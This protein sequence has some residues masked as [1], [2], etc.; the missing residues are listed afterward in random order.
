MSIKINKIAFIAV[1]V[2]M[3]FA[4]CTTQP[5]AVPDGGELDY[6]ELVQVSLGSV[7]VTADEATTRANTPL[8]DGQKFRLYAFPKGVT[9]YSKQITSYSYTMRGGSP[10]IDP[11]QGADALYLPYGE[12]DIYMVS[13]SAV[14]IGE[15]VVPDNPDTPEDES[16]TNPI[17]NEIATKNGITVPSGV[18]FLAS[19]TDVTIK[20][21]ESNT[22]NPAVLTHKMAQVQVRVKALTD[23]TYNTLKLISV[24]VDGQTDAPQPFILGAGGGS[25]TAVEA[26]TAQVTLDNI[27]EVTAGAEYTATAVVFPR[28]ASKMKVEI[29]FL[30]DLKVAEGEEP[31]QETYLM[32][33][34]LSDL[35][36]EGGKRNALKTEPRTSLEIVW[37]PEV[38][39]WDNKPASTMPLG[40]VVFYFDGNDAPEM[41]DGKLSWRDRSGSG[42]HAVLEGNVT[43]DA[44]NKCYNLS[45]KTDLLRLPALGYIPEYTLELVTTSG[46]VNND[47]AVNFKE[48]SAAVRREIGIY[49]PYKDHIT[50]FDAPSSS[51]RITYC[52]DTD[53]ETP[54]EAQK[55][56]MYYHTFRTYHFS[57]SNVTKKGSMGVNGV[58]K[59]V[60]N[61]IATPHVAFNVNQLGGAGAIR[62]RSARLYRKV[63]TP[64]QLKANYDADQATYRQQ[65]D[66]VRDASL[67]LE[68]DGKVPPYSDGTDTY[69]P[70]MSGNKNHAKYIHIGGTNHI[71]YT[72]SGYRFNSNST[73]SSSSCMKLKNSL[74]TLHTYTLEIVCNS[75]KQNSTVFY[76]GPAENNTL[77]AIGIHLPHVNASVSNKS[78]VY[79]DSP[80]NGSITKRFIYDG[81]QVSLESL[82]ANTL[83]FAFTRQYV[84]G[85]DDNLMKILINGTTVATF[86]PTV[87]TYQS[88]HTYIGNFAPDV[89]LGSYYYVGEIK[90]IRLYNRVL[91]DAEILKNRNADKVRYKL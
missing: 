86:V 74:G 70:D 80:W 10:V 59:K 54:V 67:L 82:T 2:V 72:G 13:P 21:G 77:R 45:T 37:R 20:R 11:G 39:P 81:P 90:A 46:S 33:G 25:I 17:Y 62:L 53:S 49:L 23:A 28:K 57:K 76:S 60:V 85:A 58:E 31:R 4:G 29:M 16:A 8:A 15:D 79:F 26:G 88:T 32:S 75:E 18:D 68:L 87:A 65:S 3:I 50:Y 38:L 6:S 30:A 69:W 40:D 5:V 34:V 44:A 73:N 66:I 19:K 14:Q 7:S 43:Y 91:T 83:S 24:N 36:L 64:T 35:A 78:A 61:N 9:D 55:D 71:A 41:I 52:F 84:S 47:M 1:W 63:L 42:N 27:T 48:S 12:V 56:V 89:V 51:D 22:I